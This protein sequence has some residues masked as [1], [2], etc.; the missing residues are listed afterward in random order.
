MQKLYCYADENTHVT[1]NSKFVVAV[2]VVDTD[3]LELT[4]IV[5]SIENLCGKGKVKWRK[6]RYKYRVAYFQQIIIDSRFR[7]VLRFAVFTQ[8]VDA[9]Q[10]TVEAIARAVLWQ[11]PTEKYTTRIYIDALSKEKRHGYGTAL[12]RL[13]IPT[14]KVQGVTKDENNALIRLADAVA[15][16]IGDILDQ[17]GGPEL[18][19][20]YELGLEAKV[21]IEV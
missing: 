2:N 16:F 14:D 21:F 19:Q 1:P 11:K 5:E 13:G 9:D 8:P 10:A 18:Q 12:R 7:N 17:S 20:L 4:T 15:G 6:T 3:P